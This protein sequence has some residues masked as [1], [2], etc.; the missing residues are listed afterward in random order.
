MENTEVDRTVEELA[1]ALDGSL[2]TPL[3]EQLELGLRERIEAG[4]LA[5]G[6]ALPPEPELAERLGVSRQTVN[7]ALTNLARRGAVTRRRRAGTFVAAPFVEQP[8][9]RLYSFLRTLLAQ[10]HL[11]EMRLLGYR[12]TVDRHASPL[13]TGNAHGLVFELSR[14]RLVDGDPFVVE[15]LYLTT[16]CG[17]AL[18]LGRLEHEV[19]YDLLSEVCGSVITHAD[20]TLR[21]VVLRQPE[22]SLLG[23]SVGE[24]AFLVERTGY[25]GETAV[26][27]RRSVIRGDRYRFRVHL[28]GDTLTSPLA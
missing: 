9:D 20:E 22:A 1:R 21:P 26:E 15:T 27:L 4:L 17:E 23:L 5:A 18:P 24:P 3:Y 12:I 16:G 8:L 28:E 25:A 13:L 11:P 6:T 2:R 7:Q 14:L 10:G 19:L